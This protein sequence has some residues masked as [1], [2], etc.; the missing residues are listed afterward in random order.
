MRFI[1]FLY[2]LIISLCPLHA[3]DVDTVLIWNRLNNAI[4]LVEV[5]DSSA[6]EISREAFDMARESGNIELVAE[7]AIVYAEALALFDAYDDELRAAY[8]QLLHADR[9]LD[10]PLAAACLKDIGNIYRSAGDHYRALVFYKKALEFYELLKDGRGLAS[11]QLN[12][13]LVYK[14]TGNYPDAT[15]YFLNALTYFDDDTTCTGE[16]DILMNLGIVF[17]DQ[18]DYDKALDY[19]DK[20]LIYYEKFNDL[21]GVADCYTNIGVVHKNLED[22]TLAEDFYLKAIAIREETGNDGDL[23]RAVHNMGYLKV[24]RGDYHGGLEDYFRSL[25]IKQTTGDVHG[26]A[27]TYLNI[28]EAYGFLGEEKLAEEYFQIALDLSFEMDARNLRSAVYKDYATFYSNTGRPELAYEMT[29]RYLALN[30]SIMGLEKLRL[31]NNLE[32]LY[33]VERQ[34]LSDSLFHAESH[35]M[36]DERLAAR[37]QQRTLIMI[38]V[39]LV[40]LFALLFAWSTY[41]RLKAAKIAN[42]V[43][44]HKTEE[45]EQT[46]ISKDEKEVLLQ[47]VHH[48][49]KNNLQIINSLIRL[50]SE[51]IEDPES[52]AALRES[53]NRIIS[54]SLVHE[55]LYQNKDFANVNVDSYLSN[56][57]K[58]VSQ[59]FELG[60][61]VDIDVE[62]SAG[63]MGINTLIP[64]G[65]IVNEVISNSLK[66]AFPNGQQEPRVF[67]KLEHVAGKCKLRI[68]DN[69]K[70]MEEMPDPEKATLGLELIQTLTEQIDGEL[71]IDSSNGLTYTITFPDDR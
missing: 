15:R 35:R 18:G 71:H 61:P 32:M 2:L 14:N 26:A 11:T 69:G 25:E 50:Q 58:H 51:S 22:Y 64:V 56:L 30:D 60:K 20:A 40:G 4:D 68:G 6:I 49:V 38:S 42:E 55:E 52:L 9:A 57:V 46:R 31:I 12:L 19:Y 16:G 70:G 47:E 3:Q 44:H 66:H 27:G 36:E 65:L 23:A 59:S 67:L 34:A 39:I 48:R 10:Y 1:C 17:K 45:L 63:K 24:L 5:H 43:L 21:D 53:Q 28:A 29:Q 54:M 7:A 33:W 37:S 62:V 13:G 41:R 8:D